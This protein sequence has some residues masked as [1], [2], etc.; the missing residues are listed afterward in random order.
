MHWLAQC[1]LLNKKPKI[2]YT[3]LKLLI[4]V[5][6]Q[7]VKRKDYNSCRVINS[8][9]N[10]LYNSIDSDNNNNYYYN[11][12]MEKF[13]FLQND[14]SNQQLFFLCK[15]VKVM[16]TSLWCFRKLV[17]LNTHVGESTWLWISIT[18]FCIKWYFFCNNF[19]KNVFMTQFTWKIG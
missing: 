7:F 9:F 3:L 10:W 5:S 11:T 6:G 19:S 18:P 12:L 17:I 4:C 13:S 15:R 16:L 1:S 2:C 8:Q 14:P